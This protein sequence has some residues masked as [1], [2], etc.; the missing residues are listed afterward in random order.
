MRLICLSDNRRMLVLQQGRRYHLGFLQKQDP[1]IDVC[2]LPCPRLLHLRQG[3]EQ[4]VVTPFPLDRLEQAWHHVVQLASP[5]SA[6]HRQQA[7][8]SP[9]GRASAELVKVLVV[10]LQH[11]S[12]KTA[13]LESRI[14]IRELPRHH[15]RPGGLRHMPQQPR[16]LALPQNH[17]QE[18]LPHDLPDL[19]PLLR[20]GPG[21]AALHQQPLGPLLVVLRTLLHN[22][23]LHPPGA[24]H[25]WGCVLANGQEG[26]HDLHAVVSRGQL[27]HGVQDLFSDQ[28][29]AGPVVDGDEP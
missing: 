21:Q 18:I 29:A 28:L 3:L 27:V 2:V 16:P 11:P 10:C 13:T 1:L 17:G 6:D 15:L 25:G 8:D 4:H 20:R 7:D 5:E 9:G 22:V 23:L 14:T 19:R 26:D 24:V 12:K